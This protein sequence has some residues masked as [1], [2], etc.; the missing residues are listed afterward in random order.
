MI[1]GA[2]HRDV[3]GNGDL[4]EDLAAAIGRAAGRLGR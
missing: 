4:A 2:I 1:R 3:P